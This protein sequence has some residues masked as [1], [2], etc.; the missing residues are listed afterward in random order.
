[1]PCGLEEVHSPRLTFC[2]TTSMHAEGQTPLSSSLAITTSLDS[3]PP[4]KNGDARPIYVC[5]A[6]KVRRLQTPPIG[7]QSREECIVPFSGTCV[8][9]SPCRTSGVQ[10]TASAHSQRAEYFDSWDPCCDVRHANTRPIKLKCHPISGEEPK[11]R[12]WLAG[13]TSP[14]SVQAPQS[15][16]LHRR[17]AP[18]STSPS[19]LSLG[20]VSAAP[21]GA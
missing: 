18:F 15:P 5:E 11:R 12:A 2:L 16:R 8:R 1:M 9:Q 4:A 3:A 21:A 20:L 19:R 10:C 13:V 7:T 17:E 14:L 6:F